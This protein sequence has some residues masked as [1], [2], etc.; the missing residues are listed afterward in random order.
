MTEQSYSRSI[1]LPVSAEDAFRWHERPG[2]L[3][4]LI[5]RWVTR[6]AIRRAVSFIDERLNGRDGLGGINGLNGAWDAEYSNDDQFL[7]VVGAYDDAVV[8]F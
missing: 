4:R 6:A 2:A 8:S 1:E 7:Y 5:P 3:Q